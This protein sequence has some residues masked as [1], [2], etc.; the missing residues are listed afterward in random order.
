MTILIIE[1]IKVKKKNKTLY[2]NINGIINCTCATMYNSY[3]SN[4]IVKSMILNHQ[5]NFFNILFQIGWMKAEDQT[6][7]TFH[8]R[9]VASN[10]RFSVSHEN[11]RTWYLHIRDVEET[12]K[13]CYMCQ[14]NT[15]E[16]QKQISCL[17]VLGKRT[18]NKILL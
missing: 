11:Y 4:K 7:L 13:G 15:I 6:I 1:L 17:D 2:K 8:E 10:G 5:I 14:V 12:D 18:I 9:V 3:N 16:M